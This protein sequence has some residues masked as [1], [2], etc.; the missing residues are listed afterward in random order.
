MGQRM[1]NYE[2]AW[3]EPEKLGMDSRWFESFLDRLEEENISIHGF[4]VM[5]RGKMV[6]ESYYKPYDRNC[7]H[8][9]FSVAKSFV[10]VGIGFL[11]QEGKISLDAPIVKYFPEYTQGRQLDSYLEEMTIRDMLRMNTCHSKTTYKTMPDKD[12]VG[13]FFKVAPD[14]APGTVFSYD[15]SS[16]H[17]LCALIE[18]LSGKCL[19]DYLREKFMDKLGFSEET[20]C[21][22]DP[23]GV[24]MGGSG[25]MATPYDLLKFIYM[26]AC[27]GEWQGEQVLPENYIR[28]AVRKQ[29]DTLGKTA[30]TEEMQG[31]GY[32]F[33]RVRHNGWACFGMG[34]QLGVCLPDKEL[35]FVTTGDAQAVQGGVQMIY[36]A[37]WQEIY[38]KIDTNVPE[39]SGQKGEIR[40]RELKALPVGVDFYIT[41]FKFAGGKVFS[42]DSNTKGWKYISL[43]FS[44]DEGT[45][46]Y[47]NGTGKHEIRFGI[48]KN[49]IQTFPVY[50]FQT[51]VSASFGDVRTLWIKAQIIDESVGTVW[52]GVSIK[53][54]RCTLVLRKIEETLFNEFDGIISGRIR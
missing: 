4:L 32:Q 47:E 28:E 35:I 20:R 42:L 50:G 33:W 44:G 34:G 19:I 23:S 5:R 45:F 51:A 9:M 13:T 38:N 16:A 31:Y 21:L 17:T 39:P 41:A 48:G 27:G 6:Y 7:V 15:T 25:L 24:S 52:I 11:E 3:E 37:F 22:K 12:W 2:F 54:N 18:K 30:S 46:F 26:V 1:K 36:Q 29:T 10:S 49:V 14:H 8:R 40:Y 53:N 43:K